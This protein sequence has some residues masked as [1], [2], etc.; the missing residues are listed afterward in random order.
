MDEIKHAMDLD[1]VMKQNNKLFFYRPVKE[2]CDIEITKE[3]LFARNEKINLANTFC[4]KKYSPIIVSVTMSSS[5]SNH[6]SEVVRL[7]QELAEKNNND[8]VRA[9]SGVHITSANVG[10]NSVPTG[11][12]KA[13]LIGINYFGQD[14]ELHGCQNDI[15]NIERYLR[16]CGYTDFV[17]LKDDRNDPK[18]LSP[19]APTRKNILEA[20]RRLVAGAAPGAQLYIHYSG[21]G[22]QLA[23]QNRDELDG[24]DECICPID[25]NWTAEDGGFIRDDIMNEI[26]VKGLPKGVKLRV[27]F[28]SCHSGSALDLPFRWVSNTRIMPSFIVEN[29]SERTSVS[30]KDIV[31]ISGC[32]DAQ[33]SA[34]SSFNGQS[35][36]AMTWALLE[37]LHDIRKSG[38][39]SKKWTWEDLVQA[40]RIKLRVGHYDQIPQLGLTSEKQTRNFVDLI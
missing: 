7:Y 24:Q 9:S 15:A 4:R 38:Q 6:V 11:P 17:V 34:D 2:L 8:P 31:F 32:A 23:D 36:G 25:Y 27:C 21:H 5:G 35:A 13:L 40:M 1:G 20:M 33:T 14:S 26:L 3:Y 19:S 22:S 30:D 39:H 29:A 10:T 16:T 28:D 37:C 12:K 18:F